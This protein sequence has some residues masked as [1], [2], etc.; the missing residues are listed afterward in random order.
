MRF[1]QQFQHKLNIMTCTDGGF[2]LI[3][4]IQ[5]Q[6]IVYSLHFIFIYFF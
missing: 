3:G 6:L 5:S 4:V 1:N 2:C